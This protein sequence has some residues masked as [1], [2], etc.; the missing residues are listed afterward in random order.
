MESIKM[1]LTGLSPLLMH[2]GD[3]ANPLHKHAK[4][5]AKL[6][7]G[8]KGKKTEEVYMLM[9]DVEFEGGMYFDK[10]VGPYIPGECLDAAMVSGAKLTRLGTAVKR[11]AQV[12]DDKCPLIYKGPRDMDGLIASPEFRLMK[13]VKVGAAKVVRTRP[14]FSQWSLEFTWLYA[15]DQ[16]DRETLIDIAETTGRLVG[17]C[18]WRPRYGK[19]KAEVIS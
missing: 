9:S 18:D 1:K 5:L 14:M 4:A 7:K 6:S 8:A 15:P 11:G 13:P 2:N 10:D 16:F 19:F 3:M 12:L 17:L